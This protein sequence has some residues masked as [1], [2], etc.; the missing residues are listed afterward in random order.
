MPFSVPVT[1]YTDVCVINKLTF[2]FVIFLKTLFSDDS[3]KTRKI[4]S[5]FD[6]KPQ[7][8]QL[9]FITFH[10][11]CLYLKPCFAFYFYRVVLGKHNF[12]F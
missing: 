6:R 5:Y 7:S 12:L 10:T 4:I 8:F 2:E 11:L 3:S 1:K 9:Y